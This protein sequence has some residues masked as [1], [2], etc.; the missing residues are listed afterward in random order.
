MN[1]NSFLAYITAKD[2]IVL[3]KQHAIYHGKAR[4]AQ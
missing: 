4:T 1:G 3:K 2:A